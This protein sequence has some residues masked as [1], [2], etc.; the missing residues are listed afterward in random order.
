MEAIKSRLSKVYDFDQE[1]IDEMYEDLLCT[2][3]VNAEL[4]ERLTILTDWL[5]FRCN[6]FT[7]IWLAINGAMDILLI[8]N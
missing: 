5:G 7:L 8:E 2:L 1:V 6:Y 4:S 3:S